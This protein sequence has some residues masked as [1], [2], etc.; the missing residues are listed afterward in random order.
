[1]GTFFSYK[2]TDK[3]P[4]GV[5][6]FDVV[7]SETPQAGAVA[8]EFPVEVG[9]NIT[10]HVRPTLDVL[11]LEVFVSNH[12]IDIYNRV[13]PSSLRGAYNAVQLDVPVYN[14]P[15]RSLNGLLSAA[16][17]ALGGPK[18]PPKALVLTFDS[19]FSATLETWD[20]LR[21]L[22]DEARLIEAIGSDFY[23]E[24]MVITNLT[25]PKTNAE[26]SGSRFTITLK[27]IRIVETRQ[28]S[29]PV[30]AEPRA[31][32]VVNAGAK[33]PTPAGPKSST[34]FGLLF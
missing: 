28:V 16:L 6:R 24:G 7:T 18:P 4:G 3:S 23:M 25:K 29:V 19:A 27:Q 22:K 8:T 31:K 20:L 14:P 12:P 26:G 11:D 34:L 17:D 13:D 1:M 21:Q 10:D 33:G 15:I 30:P 5:L 32:A 9:A 2:A